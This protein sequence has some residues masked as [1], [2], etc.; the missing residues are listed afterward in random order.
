MSNKTDY[1]KQLILEKAAEIFAAKGY[2][3]VTM[4]DIVEACEISRGGLYLYYDSTESIFLDVIK[5]SE[6]A[7]EACGKSIV[8]SLTEASSAELLLWFLKEQKKEI[9]KRKTSLS[10]AIY[11]YAF[12]CRQEL[13]NSSIK[14]RFESAT[15]VLEKI[16][17]RGSET[18]EFLCDDPSGM[19]SNMMYAIE[20]L[21]ICARTMGIS[22]NKVDKELVY[23]MRQFMEVED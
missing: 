12:Y 8:E 20:G 23:M 14:Q 17:A 18:G 2:R 6:D 19:A 4:K 11:E 3:D 22:E 10:V 21:K 7:E 13:H 1:K 5:A 9:L 15:K 16:L